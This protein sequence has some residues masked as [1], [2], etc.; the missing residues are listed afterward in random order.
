MKKNELK[1]T[2]GVPI[3]LRVNFDEPFENLIKEAK[4]DWISED[5]RVDDFSTSRKGIFDTTVRLLSF[6]RKMGIDGLQNK[7][8]EL[9]LRGAEPRQLIQLAIVHPTIETHS[10]IVASGKIITQTGR[11]GGRRLLSYWL[12]AGEGRRHLGYGRWGKESWLQGTK[13]LVEE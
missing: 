8:C 10:Q 11:F 7:I 5:L 3:T 6:D 4:F 9:G 2:I 13:Y 1:W 12:G